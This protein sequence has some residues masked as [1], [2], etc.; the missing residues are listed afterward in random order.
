MSSGQILVISSDKALRAKISK[1]FLK[2]GV[3]VVGADGFETGMGQIAQDPPALVI[4]QEPEEVN[5]VVTLYDLLREKA[6]STPLLIALNDTNMQTAMKYMRLGAYDCLAHGFSGGDLIAA[7]KHSLTRHGRHLVLTKKTFLSR[8]ARKILFITGVSVFGV[9]FLAA[10]A[11]FIVNKYVLS[12]PVLYQVP[13]PHPAGIYWQEKTLWMADWF[14]QSIS[15]YKL[16]KK[17]GGIAPDM[18][19]SVSEFEPIGVTA[20]DRDVVYTLAND[21]LIRK[22]KILKN[23]LPVVQEQSSP[24]PAPSGIVWDGKNLWS[25]DSKTR[26]VYK[27]GIRLN[28]L[29][30]FPC[31]A[32]APGGITWDGKDFWVLDSVTQGIYK[33]SVKGLDWKFI[34]PYY[35]KKGVGQGFKVSGIAYGGKRLWTISESQGL[36][37]GHAPPQLKKK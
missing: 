8:R 16:P 26:F 34:G 17:Q 4:T 36:L 10:G 5:T 23:G 14:D 21:G 27:H 7:A 18:A 29:Q 37:V 30:S 22:H 28:V 9:A 25:C 3:P 33:L 1:T 31:P 13:S 12:R 19:M 35:F 20:S 6:P 24:G 15:A 2:S 11:T 32:E